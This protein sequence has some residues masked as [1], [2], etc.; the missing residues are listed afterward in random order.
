MFLLQ[1][2]LKMLRSIALCSVLSTSVSLI[3]GSAQVIG[4][5]G[6][7]P[8]EEMNN[9]L[10]EITNLTKLG[11]AQGVQA[12]VFPEF[13]LF[14]KSFDMASRNCNTLKEFCD[15]VPK[16]GFAKCGGPTQA[17][18]LSCIARESNMTI[19][20][21]VCELD[22]DN[23]IWNTQLLINKNGNMT[24]TYRKTHPFVRCFEVPPKPDLVTIEVDDIVFGIFTCKDIL[25]ET[26]GVTLRH[27]GI[28]KF[29]YAADIAII[30]ED[31]VRDWS[32]IHNATMV[33]SDLNHGQGGVYKH[34]ERLTSKPVSGSSVTVFDLRL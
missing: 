26:P 32:K 6:S 1:K 14:A 10:I 8:T 4:Q 15:V 30:G 22:D 28:D 20:V 2:I 34:G 16:P 31:A 21:N 33:Y 11:T 29:L 23:K 18:K 27:L 3:V 5:T 19:S 9:N 25:Y 12:L 17:D 13:G 24:Q 7:T